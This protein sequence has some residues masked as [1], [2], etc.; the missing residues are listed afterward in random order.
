MADKAGIYAIINMIDGKLYIG[1]THRLARRWR[2]HKYHLRRG[3]H[4]SILLQRAWDKHGEAA[5]RFDV[6]L[7]CSVGEETL[8]AYEQYAL[9]EFAPAYNIAF[10]ASAPMT[11]RTHTIATREKMSEAHTGKP[12]S[13]THR[14][15]IGKGQ[16]GN[17]RGP[18]TPETIKKMSEAHIGHMHTPESKLKISEGNLGKVVSAESRK[19]MSES[20]QR[21]WHPELFAS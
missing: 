8:R 16:L 7:T 5:F 21:R 3:T 9:D 10:I 1:S 19:K 11:G 20:A 14:A 12:K 15:N 4:H 18:H 13:A 2:D 17:K 6:L